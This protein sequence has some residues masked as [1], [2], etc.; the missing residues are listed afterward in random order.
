MTRVFV[1]WDDSHL[2]G[3]L[4]LRFL[5]ALGL[6]HRILRAHDIAEGALSGKPVAVGRSKGLS[7]AP[8]PLLIVPGG[9]ARGKALRLGA[10]GLAA[11]RGFVDQDGN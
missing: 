10:A 5:R 4:V 7:D 1:V 9:W 11:I 8:P 3:L 6:P 2:W